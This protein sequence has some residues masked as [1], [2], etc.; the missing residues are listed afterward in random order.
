M[1][2]YYYILGLKQTASIE[3]V[4]KAYRK[5]SLKFHPDKNDGDEFFTERFKEIQEAYETLVDMS[6]RQIYDSNRSANSSSK[7]NNSGTN[8]NPEIEY[9]KSNKNDFEYDEEVTFSWKTIN[10]DKVVLKPFGKIQPIGHKAH[11]IKDFKNA[12]LTFELV[13]ENSNTGRQIKSTL[14]LSNKTYKDLYGHFK[15]QN[16]REEQSKSNNY[17]NSSQEN[18]TTSNVENDGFSISDKQIKV[19][20]AIGIGIVLILLILGQ[21]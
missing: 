14:T 19:I 9:F 18:K 3:E 2:D 12:I 20:V 13:A 17:Q 21:K 1:K 16:R 7:Q 5:L 11:R 15:E 8:F 6:K 10:A 4:K